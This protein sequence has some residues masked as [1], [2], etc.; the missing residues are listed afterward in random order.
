MKEEKQRKGEGEG[1]TE[2]EWRERNRL[3]VYQGIHALT[4]QQ[5]NK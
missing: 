4:E 3:S 5:Y 2:E 1:E